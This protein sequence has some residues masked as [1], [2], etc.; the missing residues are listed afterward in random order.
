MTLINFC[1]DLYVY[2]PVIN[3]IML[4]NIKFNSIIIIMIIKDIYRY[5]ND[6]NIYAY[7]YHHIV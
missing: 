3:S 4:L 2:S 7:T 5:N 6:L 1:F